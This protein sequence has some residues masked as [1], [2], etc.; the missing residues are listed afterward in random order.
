MKNFI[1]AAIAI[2]ALIICS[3]SMVGSHQAEVP[4]DSTAP[5]IAGDATENPSGVMLAT[6]AGVFIVLPIPRSNDHGE[7]CYQ[8]E[9]A[10]NNA[11]EKGYHFACSLD[12][13]GM[14]ILNQTP[15]ADAALN[16]LKKQISVIDEIQDQPTAVEI[17]LRT[18]DPLAAGAPGQ[19]AGAPSPASPGPASQNNPGS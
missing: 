3:L 1:G 8:L 4:G 19:V 14:V 7:R 2:C 12:T 10:L 9:S 16:A 15:I 13:H 5:A 6:G 17:A 18:A 11:A